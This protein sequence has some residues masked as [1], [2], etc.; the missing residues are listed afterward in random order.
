MAEITAARLNNL[1]SRIELI[2]GNGAGQ[3]GYGQ[4]IASANV[5]NDGNDI[6]SGDD[7]NNIYAD[8]IRAR[9]HQV[10][11]GDI[12]IA[13][14]VKDLNIIAEETSFFVNDAGATIVDAEGV[15]K[16][17][18][19]FER[20]MTRIEA[21][22][23]LVHTSQAAIEP[24]ITS[25]RTS[26]WNGLI[27]HEVQVNF[28]SEDNRRHFFNTGGEIWIQTS[29]NGAITPKGLDWAQLCN[30]IGTVKFSANS[31]IST[32]SGGVSNSIGNYN[33]TSASQQIY[34]KV[35]SGNNS[36][37][38]AGN[39]YTIRARLD[40]PLRITF[41]I[42]FN[43]VAFVGSVDNNV[44]GRLE[45]KITQYRAVGNFVEVSSP[46]YFNATTLSTFTT[47]IEVL[48]PPPP[49]PPPPPS[50]GPLSLDSAVVISVID[51]S[52][53]TASTI[54]NDWNSFRNNYPNRVFWLLQPAGRSPSELKVP[55]SYIADSKANGPVTVNR[56]RGTVSQRSDWFSICGLESLSAG[57]VVSLAVDNSGS[58]TTAQVRAS[59]DFFKQRCSIAGLRLVEQSMSGERW[60]PPHN[61]SLP[62][63]TVL[64]TPS[65][66]IIGVTNNPSTN[67]ILNEGLYTAT[68]TV[69][70]TNV[71]N[72]TVLFWSTDTITGTVN[73]NDFTDNTLTGSVTINNNTGTFTRSARADQL[74]EGLE[75]FRIRLRTGSTSGT[76]V[77]TSNSISIA[78]T[79]QT[80]PPTYSIIGVTN[81]PS[82]NT[83]INE[84]EFTAT[85]TVTTTNVPDGTILFWTTTGN[86]TAA[87]FTDNTL[88]GSITIN[89][90]T[91]TITRSARADSLTEGAES[92]TIVLRSESL[93]SGPVVAISNSISIA[94]TSLTPPPAI[95]TYSIAIINPIT[96]VIPEGSSGTYTV[97]TTNVANGTVLYW[98]I[99]NLTTSNIDFTATSG[100]FT[101]SG[102]LGTFTITA[103]ADQLTEG[104]ESFTVH[105]RT[106]ST[107]GTIVT[108]ASTTID[109]TSQSPTYSMTVDS[110]R[111]GFPS[112]GNETTF[113]TFTYT[114][115]TTNVP[116]G[117]VLYW[118][119][120]QP[121]SGSG[122]TADDFVDG[123]TGTVT[124]N[125]NIGT[126][127]RTAR[128]DN[129]T[130]GT[131]YFGTRLHTGSTS[132]PVVQTGVFA[133]I[134][135]TST[136]PPPPPTI[137]FIRFTPSS[138]FSDFSISTTTLE[139]STSGAART[140]ISYSGGNPASSGGNPNASAS[141][142]I[143]LNASGSYN[144]TVQIFDSGGASVGIQ[145]ATFTFL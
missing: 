98:T 13:E 99:T 90:N 102:N 40:G 70:T 78:D 76:I 91:A 96:N 143:T 110:G 9:I 3:N 52:S 43:D 46:S 31:T 39:L 118:T 54:S 123:L 139:W 116:N 47:P 44:D 86:I 49:P 27:F 6:I 23:F 7:L 82:S 89:N 55:S 57:S 24:K 10:G 132:G 109:D 35:G 117:T 112:V 100:S 125:N 2:L 114:V 45:S 77:A 131:E 71:A 106:G 140:A 127:T 107:S 94:D 135:D 81:N 58:M 22:K 105:V 111:P 19:D 32:G 28:T 62:S 34:Q 16:G 33:L 17:I 25:V 64:I 141:G 42:E 63:P 92:F 69:T 26:A 15:K 36:G 67:T 137:N 145:S 80:L 136:T 59:Y 79:S 87:D 73:A 113:S 138:N 122:V 14:V 37:I 133:A 97:T 130:E 75:T 120:I 41:R 20:L 126:F 74:T 121:F 129:L 21:D 103:V 85:F 65:Y 72:G 95:P 108:S 66:S 4:L 88:T 104:Q 83:E 124:I 50:S 60:A 51:E 134:Q 30:E 93:G 1:Q 61:R 144:A 101:I 8:M 11:P 12:E 18:A 68:F 84:G 53:P 142:S 115:T 48:P 56:D 5:L 38:Y 128:A 119:T 29:N